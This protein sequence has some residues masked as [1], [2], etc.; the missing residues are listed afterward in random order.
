MKNSLETRIGIF[1][2]LTALA[3][4]F[5]LEML[6]GVERFT[7]GRHLFA[8]F[9]AVQEL[10]VVDR[11]QMAGVEVGRVEKI[12]LEENEN[13][14]RVTM[15]IRK[16]APIKTDSLATVKFA[17]LL[18]QNFVSINFGS[19]PAPLAVDGAILSTTEQP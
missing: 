9:N 15:K 6:G 5:I 8:R 17:G 1:V 7:R 4:V 13:T 18:G 2:A 11:V 10:K 16:S 14:V 3:A 12:E 19:P